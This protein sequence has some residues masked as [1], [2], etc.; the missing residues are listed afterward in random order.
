ME[1]VNVS[2]SGPMWLKWVEPEQRESVRTVLTVHQFARTVAFVF[3]RRLR[4]KRRWFG[5]GGSRF[6]VSTCGNRVAAPVWTM[7]I[8]VIMSVVDLTRHC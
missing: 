4:T 6:L 3:S 8:R 1:V 2:A 7:T 5:K